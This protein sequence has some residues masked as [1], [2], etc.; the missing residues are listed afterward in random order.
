MGHS[1]EILSQHPTACLLELK[2]RERQMIHW[3]VMTASDFLA[4]LNGG[5]E[6]FHAISP[7]CKYPFPLPRMSPTTAQHARDRVCK[8]AGRFPSP[9]RHSAQDD[10]V[11]V[12]E[13]EAVPNPF[14]ADHSMA[15]T[16]SAHSS[17]HPQ[18]AQH[19]PTALLH[20]RFHQV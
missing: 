17:L 11:T 14:P 1:S 20:T 5:T 18:H 7:Q 12:A 15:A 19:L 9:T 4:Q 10:A 13:A 2:A 16:S 8:V 6:Y 3:W